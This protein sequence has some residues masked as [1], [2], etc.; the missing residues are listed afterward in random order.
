MTVQSSRPAPWVR[1]GWLVAVCVTDGFNEPVGFEQPTMREQWILA[2]G[3][4]FP[5][6]EVHQFHSTEDVHAI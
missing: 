4:A 5:D 6:H 1:P 3:R 2:H